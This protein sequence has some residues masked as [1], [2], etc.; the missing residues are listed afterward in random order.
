MIHQGKTGGAHFS[1]LDAFVKKSQG[2][3]AVGSSFTIA[4]AALFCFLDLTQPALDDKLDAA[5]PD[6]QA[7]YKRI[8]ELPELQSYRTE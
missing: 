3:Y 6:L 8:A 1:Y 4:D 5:Y 2:S 7:Y